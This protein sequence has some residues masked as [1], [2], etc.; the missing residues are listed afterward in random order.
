MTNVLNESTQLLQVNGPAIMLIHVYLDLMGDEDIAEADNG[1]LESAKTDYT[2]GEI[3][4]YCRKDLSAEQIP[5]AIIDLL[6]KHLGNASTAAEFLTR[7]LRGRTLVEEAIRT[8]LRISPTSEMPGIAQLNVV[9]QRGQ[10]LVE[11][12]F[13]AGKKAVLEAVD[14]LTIGKI[15]PKH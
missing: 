14:L 4:Y 7:D 2:D 1:W 15:L 5:E 12:M 6:K 13:F 11:L 8:N 9:N 10:N 3:Y